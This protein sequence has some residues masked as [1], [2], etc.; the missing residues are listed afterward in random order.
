MEPIARAKVGR[1]G[2]LYKCRVKMKSIKQKNVLIILVPSNILLR[3]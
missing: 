2:R 1:E 3:I